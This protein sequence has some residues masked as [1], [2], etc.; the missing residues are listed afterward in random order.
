MVPSGL[1]RIEPDWSSTSMMFGHLT[2]QAGAAARA[3]VT[4]SSARG[5][6]VHL[7]S[8]AAV[9]KNGAPLLQHPAAR[10]PCQQRGSG[11]GRCGLEQLAGCALAAAARTLDQRARLR[12]VLAHPD[13]L[14]P[15]QP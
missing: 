7:Q 12:R 5:F 1:W 15:D 9:V 3:S 14:A 2:A 8:E 13:A 10:N 4:T 6:M 11:R